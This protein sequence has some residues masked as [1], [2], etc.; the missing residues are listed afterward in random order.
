MRTESEFIIP[1]IKKSSTLTEANE[2]GLASTEHTKLCPLRHDV[3][4]KIAARFYKLVLR[5]RSARRPI[6][7]PTFTPTFK[8]SSFSP[9]KT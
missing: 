4:E 8:V 9:N 6:P 3:L 7:A 1:T 5:L 2:P